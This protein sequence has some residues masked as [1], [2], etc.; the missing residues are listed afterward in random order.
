MPDGV[1][2]MFSLVLTRQLIVPLGQ[3]LRGGVHGNARVVITSRNPWV[4][5]LINL[6][7]REY[8]LPIFIGRS[9]DDVDHARPAGEL[10]AS[11]IGTL[12]QLQSL[13]GRSTAAVLALSTGIAAN[14]ANNRLSNLERKG[15]LLRVRRGRRE[16]D[17]YLDPR[18]EPD[19]QELRRTAVR[20]MRAALV[21]S[22]TESSR[23]SRTDVM[24][25]G[26]D[27]EPAARRRQGKAI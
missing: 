5:E 19:V 1:S 8:S 11:E 4:L 24:S 6:L 7:A 20:P 25:E 27:A 3:R 26:E 21:Q 18:T 2:S 10:T 14:A 12:D 15:Y 17:E 9:P 22:E 13:G 23:Y 16:G